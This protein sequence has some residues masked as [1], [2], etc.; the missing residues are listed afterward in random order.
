M[1]ISHQIVLPLILRHAVKLLAWSKSHLFIVR[2]Y[3]HLSFYPNRCYTLPHAHIDTSADSSRRLATHFQPKLTTPQR[4]FGALSPT[5][6]WRYV[7]VQSARHHYSHC[8]RSSTMAAATTLRSWIRGPR[9][10]NESALLTYSQQSAHSSPL[11]ALP[12][13]L[14]VDIASLAS[15]SSTL[16]AMCQT[17]KKLQGIATAFL[18]A[19]VELLS[20]SPNALADAA[21]SIHGRRKF[22]RL[23]T[24]SLVLGPQAS[25]FDYSSVFTRASLRTPIAQRIWTNLTSLKLEYRH[26]FY[27]INRNMFLLPALERLTLST[28]P[29][30]PER[31][32]EP[33]RNL[34]GG[35]ISPWWYGTT[36]LRE[37]QVSVS[38]ISSTDLITALRLPAALTHLTMKGKQYSW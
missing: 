6:A 13:E 30:L 9:R 34:T 33:W 5:L 1:C 27:I 11:L 7:Q 38:S 8:Y 21:L 19:N 20:P 29:G 36:P 17:C 35:G 31:V 22:T 26:P 4:V 28:Q 32:V 16:A 14:I 37:L 23:E 12:D 2:I 24:L 10:E 18:Y 3:N 25:Y 15:P